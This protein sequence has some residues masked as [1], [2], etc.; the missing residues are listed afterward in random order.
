MSS[1]VASSPTAVTNRNDAS[2]RFDT[3][4]ATATLNVGHSVGDEDCED[5]EDE[6]HDTCL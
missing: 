4:F 5:D 6:T 1:S 2:D 3:A